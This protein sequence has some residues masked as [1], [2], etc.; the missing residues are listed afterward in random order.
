MDKL[1]LIMHDKNKNK[2]KPGD[3][4]LA[5]GPP[6]TGKTY[7]ARQVSRALGAPLFKLSITDSLTPEE[8]FFGWTVVNGQLSVFETPLTMGLAASHNG[9]AVILLDEIDKSQP[10]VE[11]L[12]LPLLEDSEVFVMGRKITYV[13]RNLLFI[14]T[15]NNRRELRE[16]TLRRFNIRLYVGYSDETDAAVFSSQGLEFKPVVRKILAKLRETDK[17]K[18]PSAIEMANVIRLVKD[19]F[20]K[21]VIYTSMWKDTTD[22]VNIDKICGFNVYKALK[23]EYTS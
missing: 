12:L 10:R 22:A 19:G 16:E 18:A 1:E 3:K 2:L 21:D 17:F 4:I 7:L 6:G 15:S 9:E 8:L 11:D 13:P 23:A 14:A 5:F 20:H